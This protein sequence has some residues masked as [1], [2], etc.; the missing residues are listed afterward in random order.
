MLAFQE[1][2]RETSPVRG[3]VRWTVRVGATLLPVVYMTLVWYISDQP[4]GA[5]VHLGPYDSAIKESLH[6]VAFGLLFG[7]LSLAFAAWGLLTPRTL[8]LAA[9]FSVAYGA[10]DELHQ[11]WVP[12]RSATLVDF[13]KNS[14]G[15]VLAWFLLYRWL[16]R[17]HGPQ[18]YG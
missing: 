3:A 5:P 15:V 10:L 6:L 14:V 9:W 8:G 16:E 4:R 2:S 1:G 7:F 13:A 18:D 11:A 17:R 12:T